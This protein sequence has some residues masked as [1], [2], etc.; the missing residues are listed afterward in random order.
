[1][2]SWWLDSDRRSVQQHAYRIEVTDSTGMQ[3]WDSGDTRSSQQTGI[4]YGGP[5]LPSRQRA[6]W[7]V[8]VDDGTGPGPWSDEASFEIGLLSP[9]DW[10][11]SWIAMDELRAARRGLRPA[12]RFR[13]EFRAGPIDQARLYITCHGIYHARI[14]G[15]PVSLDRLRPGFTSYHHRL[16]YQTYD[17]TA[18]VEEGANVLAI[19]VGDGWYRGKFGPI[20]ARNSFGTSLALLAQLEI[21]H[22]DGTTTAVETGEGWLASTGPRL[23]SSFNDG[24]VYDAR[25]E[26]PGWDRAGFPPD[27]WTPSHVV[28]HDMNRLIADDVPPVRAIENITPVEVVRIAQ[29][30]WRFDLGQNIAGH[31][32]LRV[33]GPAGHAVNVTYGEILSPDGGV[34]TSPFMGARQRLVYI[35]KGGELEEFEPAF[36]YHGFRYVEVADLPGEAN[37]NTITGVVT[38]SDLDRTGHFECSDADLNRLQENITWSQRANMIEVPTDCPHR[39]KAG[40][41]GDIEAYIDTATFLQDVHL[42]MARWLGDLAADQRADGNVPSVIPLMKTYNVWPLRAMHGSAGWGDASTVVPWALYERYGDRSVLERQYQSMQAWVAFLDR[43]ASRPA[44]RLRRPQLAQG[45]GENSNV[46]T[47]G[48]HWGDWLAPGRSAIANIGVNVRRP[49]ALVATAFYARSVDLTRRAAEVLGLEADAHRYHALLGNIRDG[50]CASFVQPDGTLVPD[51]QSSYVLALHFGLLPREL[52]AAAADRLVELVE[53]AGHHPTTGFL[54]TPYLCPVLSDHGRDDV[55]YRL[56]EQRTTPS[57]LA[58]VAAG[59]TTMWEQWDMTRK[60]GRPAKL[61]YNH[62]AFGAIADWLHRYA[63]G[64]DVSRI[65][66]GELCFRPRTGGSLQWAR[67]SYDSVFGTASCRWARNE[68][69][70]DVDATIPPNL[71]ADVVLD[72]PPESILESGVP[73][74]DAEGVAAARREGGRT[75]LT[76]GSGRYRFHVEPVRLD[77]AHQ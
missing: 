50:F 20:P 38:G 10:S 28:M 26:Q 31:V 65:G 22:A 42:F 7:R 3:L 77:E 5:P 46:I 8:R 18:L 66:L 14:N 19:E 57:W 76:I 4:R 58:Q 48:Y 24:E 47:T 23:L 62:Y 64:L 75:R 73:V 30:R 39:E 9:T 63:A 40:W 61:S 12:Q 52:V 37:T 15:F 25:L 72:G 56:V 67:A 70:L 60:D 21:T 29:G 44:R 1:M 36:V 17:V 59:A 2:F 53:A 16:Q 69:G 55:A 6:R 35:L 68:R 27:G 71:C 45:A 11:A 34:D 74:A 49:H 32:R 54:S 13:H 41:T 33:R 51:S 43:R